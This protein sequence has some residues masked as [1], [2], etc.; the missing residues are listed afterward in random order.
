MSTRAPEPLRAEAQ[1]LPCPHTDARSPTILKPVA[2]VIELL[3]TCNDTLIQPRIEQCRSAEAGR[4]CRPQ[5]IRVTALG[6]LAHDRMFTVSP[7]DQEE[8]RR[9]LPSV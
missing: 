4:R 8:M 7:L 9:T 6:P 5:P 1:T 2:R 3:S